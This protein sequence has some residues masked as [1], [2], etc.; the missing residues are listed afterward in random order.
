MVITDD[1]GVHDSGLVMYP[2]GHA[3]NAMGPDKVDLKDI[4]S[5]KFQTLGKLAADDPKPIIKQIS[6]LEKKSAKDVAKLY[7]F[8]I[9][10]VAFQ[11]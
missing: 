4:L 6:G 2:G 8:A 10:P 1:G 9:R 3:R 5:H 11:E 7:D